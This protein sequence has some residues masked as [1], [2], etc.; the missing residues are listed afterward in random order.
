LNTAGRVACSC[1]GNVFLEVDGGLV[2]PS[3]SEGILP[4]IMRDSVI[5]L[6]K[7]AGVKVREKQVKQT[8]IAKADAMF[9]TNSLRFV[10][11]VT[12][13]DDNRFSTR[14]RLL[15]TVVR[16][17]LNIEQDQIILN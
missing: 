12:R 3:L 7:Q 16:G 4:G 1:I 2:T 6:A 8:D 11:S 14:S 9:I 15:D 17:L 13:C 10:R 5:R